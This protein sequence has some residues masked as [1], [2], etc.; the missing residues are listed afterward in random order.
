MIQDNQDLF[1]E[2]HFNGFVLFP[3]DKNNKIVNHCLN[4]IK[5]VSEE[6]IKEG[7]FLDRDAAVGKEGLAADLKHCF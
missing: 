1:E 4:E 2:L 6:K 3:I 5:N 7:F